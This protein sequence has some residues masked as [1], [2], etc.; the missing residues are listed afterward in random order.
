MKTRQL[1]TL[2]AVFDLPTRANVAFSEI[3]SLVRALGG[4]VVE[5][6]GSRVIFDMGGDVFHAHRPHPGKD[7][8]KYQIEGFR[9]F[10]KAKGISP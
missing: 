10:L 9:E 2:H 6:E 4:S 8:K 3:E 7:A 5:R 1:K